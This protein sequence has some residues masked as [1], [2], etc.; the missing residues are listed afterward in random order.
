VSDNL[1]TEPSQP[2]HLACRHWKLTWNQNFHRRD[3]RP[4]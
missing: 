2:Q 1:G 3:M 4:Q